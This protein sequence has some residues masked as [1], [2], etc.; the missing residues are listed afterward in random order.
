MRIIT[1][2]VRFTQL[3]WLPVLSDI[4]PLDLRR[5]V[6]TELMLSK[7]SNYPD[8]PVQIDIVNHPPE[9]LIFRNPMWSM[10]QSNK[11]IEETWANRWSTSNARNHSLI[12]VPDNRVLGFELNQTQWTALNRLRTGQGRCNYL[13]HKWGMTYSPLC[14]CSLTQTTSHIV[15]ECQRTRFEGGVA[16]LHVCG[17]M[18]IKWLEELDIRL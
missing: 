4:A 8:L 18:A 9:R 16:I 5:Q 7:L 14:E 13:L 1:G 15:E 17:P 10:S 12:S 11:S 6:Q 3:D 2:T